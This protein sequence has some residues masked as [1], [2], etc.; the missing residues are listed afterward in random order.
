MN[1][2]LHPLLQTPLVP[3]LKIL[4]LPMR[5]KPL[6]NAMSDFI[7]QFDGKS[8]D[9][10]SPVAL[11]DALRARGGGKKGR[12]EDAEEW[13]GFLLSG[14]H[15]ELLGFMPEQSG[16]ETEQWNE[17]GS[18]KR[19]VEARYLLQGETPVSKVFWGRWRG[20]VKKGSRESVTVEPFLCLPLDIAR[21]GV[22]TIED[23]L[24]G[25]GDQEVL[26]GGRGV[27]RVMLERLPGVLVV[28]LK[29]FV[30]EGGGVRKLA[31]R[32]GLGAEVRLED[33]AFY[34][35]VFSF[36]Y[37]ADG[38]SAILS[39]PLRTDPLP[40]YRLVGVVYHLGSAAGGG[41]YT[42]AVRTDK[43]WVAIDDTTVEELGGELGERP[44]E[45][46]LLFYCRVVG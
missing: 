39:P 40:T 6:L 44:G 28:Q 24:R 33:G 32:V 31:K 17:V 16:G 21:E 43:G 25:F 12:Q 35:H 45:A 42:C 13:L 34:L 1:S 29:R 26:D 5:G 4:P 8:K 11:Y 22:E 27:K 46:Y 2:A 38:L 9:P 18:G 36:D 3:L 19:T 10:F 23:A 15:E 14:L 30:Y 7:G 37:G 20:V 41:H